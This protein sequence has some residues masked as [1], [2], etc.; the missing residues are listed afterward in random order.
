MSV[1]AAA[2][3]PPQNQC[4][5]AGMLCA[6]DGPCEGR[7]AEVCAQAGKML[8]AVRADLAQRMKAQFGE[9]CPCTSGQCSADGCS[10]CEFLKSMVFAPLLREKV[11]SRTTAAPITFTHVVRGGDGKLTVAPCTFKSGGTCA[12]CERELA[13]AAWQKGNELLF[14]PIAAFVQAVHERVVA[15][16]K[17]DGSFS[18]PCLKGECRPGDCPTCRDVKATVFEPMLKQRVQERLGNL[19]KDF[20]H[21]VRIDGGTTRTIPCTFLRGGPC[22]YC[23]EEFAS[24][25]R[26]KLTE[27][28]TARR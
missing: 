12:P 22:P 21:T 1:T 15:E 4:E 5:L 18:C 26:T 27:V 19:Q 24:A 16:V 11:A 25:V 10:G 20:T 14:A 23:A 2:E 17:S 13:D 6:K 7:C 8:T 28:A 3:A 9:V